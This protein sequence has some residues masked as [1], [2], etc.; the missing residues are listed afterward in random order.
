MAQ[1]GSRCPKRRRHSLS[2]SLKRWDAR[3]DLLGLL[4]WHPKELLRQL[5]VLHEALK[6][7]IG[8]LR[9]EVHLLEL[10]VKVLLT[11]G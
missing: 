10:G 2:P 4:A 8:H 7:E 6:L 5:R 9:L 3:A 1:N 11:Q